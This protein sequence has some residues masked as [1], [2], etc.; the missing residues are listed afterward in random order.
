MTN[1]QN[2]RSSHPITLYDGGG[3]YFFVGVFGLPIFLGSILDGAWNYLVLHFT[4]SRLKTGIDSA[5]DKSAFAR[6]T[7]NKQQFICTIFITIVGFIIDYIY[8]NI[9]WGEVIAGAPHIHV[10]PVFPSNGA[11]KALELTSI[12]APMVAI[13]LTSFILTL[14]FF[15]LK[16][17]Q[18][19]T[20]GAV[21]GLFTA[22]WLI[23]AVILRRP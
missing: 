5:L 4:I 17:K 6:R 13:A 12:L 1:S 10:Q 18:A 21:M 23:I 7:R 20:L 3:W 14:L 9:F 2:L 15:R 19:L 22:P 11:N 8:Y 16:T